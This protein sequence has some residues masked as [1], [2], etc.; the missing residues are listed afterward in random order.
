MPNFN[1]KLSKDREEILLKFKELI[2]KAEVACN[3]FNSTHEINGDTYFE[4][5][6]SSINL[7]IRLA[8]ENSIYVHE[9]KEMTPNVFSIKGVL[10]AARN[11]YLQGFMADHKLLV[12]AEVFTDMLV[13]AEVLLDYDYKDA[14]AVICRAVLE[15]GLRKLCES[16]KIEIEKKETIDPLNTKLYKKN[17][18]SSLVHKEI[19]AKANI[20]NSAAH[21]KFNKYKKEDVVMFREYVLRFLAEYLK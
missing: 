8:S 21:G 16:H 1:P 3:D 15:N 2:D 20:G 13:Q 14:A 5:R 19:T 11:D 6:V 10:E 7:L 4:L 12:S 18:Y 9:L 17:V